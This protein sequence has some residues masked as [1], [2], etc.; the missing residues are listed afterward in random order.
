ML[1]FAST[2]ARLALLRPAYSYIAI[3]CNHFGINKSSSLSSIV[4]CC[5]LFIKHTFR[6]LVSVRARAHSYKSHEEREF[7]AL[8]TVRSKKLNFNTLV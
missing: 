3:H 8:E 5:H 4:S 2:G 1:T 6:N 7:A